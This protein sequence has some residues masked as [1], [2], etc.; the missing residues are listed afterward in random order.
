M[1]LVVFVLNDADKLDYLLESLYKEKI[2]AGTI[3]DSIGMA[4]KVKN[5]NNNDIV[6]IFKDLIV[7]PREMNY[8]MLFCLRDEQV[9]CFKAVANKVTG[10]LDNPNTGVLMILPLEEVMGSF[11]KNRTE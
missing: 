1:K 7:T 11:M 8:T 5:I 4:S 10:G 6:S 9:E 3:L 2:G